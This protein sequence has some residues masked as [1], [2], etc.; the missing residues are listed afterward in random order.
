VRAVD[1]GRTVDLVICF[2]CLSLKVFADGAFVANGDL[3]STQ[4][5]ELSAL[6][7][8]EGLTIAPR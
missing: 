1:G 4:E 2:E 5:P 8:A 6:Y 3:A 7:V